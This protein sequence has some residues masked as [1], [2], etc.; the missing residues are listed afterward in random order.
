MEAEAKEEAPK[1]KKRV[2]S[3]KAIY[4]CIHAGC[5]SKF[6]Q[7]SHV[8]RHMENKH[9]ATNSIELKRELKRA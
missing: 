9:K 4:C 1:A 5:G 7:M 3:R 6:D 8:V 2:F